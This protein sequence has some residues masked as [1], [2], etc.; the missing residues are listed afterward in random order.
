MLLGRCF[1]IFV[2]S[3]HVPTIKFVETPYT[4]FKLYSRCTPYTLHTPHTLHTL[5]ALHTLHF[6]WCLTFL[7][8]P[9]SAFPLCLCLFFFVCFLLLPSYPRLLLCTRLLL[10]PFLLFYSPLSSS[11]RAQ[12]KERGRGIRRRRRP[13]ERHQRGGGGG[14]YFL[15]WVGRY[16]QSL[17]SKFRERVE[18]GNCFRELQKVQKLWVLWTGKGLGSAHANLQR[19]FQFQAQCI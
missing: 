12:G 18:T 10:F 11:G 1:M 15:T 5:H 19:E 2:L 14:R 16:L 8:F 9:L 6:Y 13:R 7:G 4:T 17:D 3:A